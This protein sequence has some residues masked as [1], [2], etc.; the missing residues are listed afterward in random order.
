MTKKLS[1]RDFLR[2]SGLTAAAVA[3]AACSSKAEP[4]IK[5]ASLATLV[6]EKKEKITIWVSNPVYLKFWEP[7][8]EKFHKANPDFGHEVEVLHVSGGI[9]E[10]FIAALIAGRGAPDSVNIADSTM[11]SLL[12]GDIISETLH[13]LRPWLFENY[14]NYNTEFI[15]WEPYTAGDG[16]IYG[17]DWSLSQTVYY[18]RKDLHDAAG[19]DPTAYVTYKD[20]IEGGKKFNEF[21]PGKFSVV[22]DVGGTDTFRVLATQNGGG[23]FDK[24]GNILIDSPKNV[25]ALQ[26]FYDM[27]NVHKMAWPCENVWGPGMYAALEDGTCAGAL[28]ADW[29][30][31]SVLVPQVPNQSGKWAVAK[32]PVFKEGGAPSAQFGG[33]GFCITQ[34]SKAPDAVWEL[35]NFVLLTKEGQISKHQLAQGFPTR[36]DAMD[37]PSIV[38]FEDPYFGG[39]KSGAVLAEVAPFALGLPAH[40][41]LAEAFEL[42][43]PAVPETIGDEKTPEVALKDAADEL[44][45]VIEQG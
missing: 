45:K 41:F 25:E 37:D 4:T 13:D 27:V 29:Y 28:G 23:Y 15:K 32:M 44:R 42:L 8:L 24:D 38:E 22:A 6:P 18:Y 30:K 7:G 34:Q 10:K 11:S 21:H 20:F 43:R 16:K 17:I 19:V 1:R 12:K 33:G 40:P 3:A 2:G 31:N 14:P 39:Q 26:L 35:L 36:L 5:A 9:Y